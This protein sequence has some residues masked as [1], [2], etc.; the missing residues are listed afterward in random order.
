MLERAAPD[1][2]VV[3]RHL[4]KRFHPRELQEIWKSLA[5]VPRGANG[6]V[7]P[8]GIP[9]P[10]FGIE[11]IGTA[12]VAPAF[13]SPWTSEQAGFYWIEPDD[14][15]STDIANTYGYGGKPRKTIP[16][17]L[18]AGSVVKLVGNY[19]TNHTTPA[20]TCNGTS[21]N[22]V[23]IRGTD[24]GTRPTITAGWYLQGSYAV[25]EFVK[26][27]GQSF[28]HLLAPIDHGVWRHS[29]YDGLSQT[30][31]TT[32]CAIGSFAHDANFSDYCV[33]YD[34]HI[35]DNG[36][37]SQPGDP[38]HHGIKPFTNARNL[39]IVDCNIHDVQGDGVQIDAGNLTNQPDTNH[40]YIGRNTAATN[41]Q[42]G[43]WCKYAQDVI[44]SQNIGHHM[45]AGGT[46]GGGGLGGWQYDADQVWLLFNLGYSQIFGMGVG[47]P[48]SD[49]GQKGYVIG[50]VWYDIHVDPA[51]PNK[52]IC[53]ELFGALDVQALFN[54]CADYDIGISRNGGSIQ[55]GRYANNI[56]SE[57][58][59]A[60]GGYDIIDYFDN[61]NRLYKNNLYRAPM[62]VSVAGTTYTTVAALEGALGSRATGN[63]SA[64]P[65][66]AD[67]VNRNY[68]L[69]T[70][71]PCKDA[72]L[73]EQAF[74]DF[75]NSYGLSIQYDR[76]GLGRPVGPAWDMG[77]YEYATPAGS[78][79]LEGRSGVVDRSSWRY[80]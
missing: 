61:A 33:V 72:A 54:T 7:R 17:T 9:D 77:A 29:E 53:M 69:H 28:L 18:P 4:N 58:L 37:P 26:F 57:R 35:H 65:L 60:A 76:D 8:I 22:P 51:A 43:Y 66:F 68:H 12:S 80:G 32:C 30:P 24:T 67:S 46:G 70:A 23:W 16:T 75:M 13:P 38:D 42:N 3:L 78:G 15:N 6:W 50:N 56:F 1:V 20:I 45:V 21:G 2:R 52:G 62:R 79:S 59:V 27:S 71:S 41:R 5:W 49:F 36:L 31:G 63:L 64:D 55:K 25:L 73:S 34:V 39:W 48:N 40:I 10:P 11:G 19:T 47:S 74:I 44:M 14:V